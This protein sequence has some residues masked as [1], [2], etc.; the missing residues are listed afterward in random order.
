MLPGRS[1]PTFQRCLLPLTSEKVITMMMEVASTS[2]TL[3]NFH[4]TK[5][6][7]NWEDS[8]HDITTR[9]SNRTLTM[10][11]NQIFA[12]FIIYIVHNFL[13]Y[14]YVFITAKG[15]STNNRTQLTVLPI[16]RK[17]ARPPLSAELPELPRWR[18]NRGEALRLTVLSSYS[19]CMSIIS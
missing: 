16:F 1:S 9:T 14:N 11:K 6:H 3:V 15:H 10:I 18:E 5:Q 13:K 2:E 19:D 4:Q 7:N 12:S 8:Y 17:P